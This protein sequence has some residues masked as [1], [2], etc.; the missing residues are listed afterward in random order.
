MAPLP[1]GCSDLLY[2]CLNVMSCQENCRICFVGRL[3]AKSEDPWGRLPAESLSATELLK[4]FEEKGFSAQEFV[5]LS[6]AHTV[7]PC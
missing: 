7:S 6:G 5:A 4:I 3:D 2:R 1:T